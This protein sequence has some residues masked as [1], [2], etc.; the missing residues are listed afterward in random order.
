MSGTFSVLVGFQPNWS[1]PPSSAGATITSPGRKESADTHSQDSRP[2]S[3]SPRRSTICSAS[4]SPNGI[5]SS[6]S[7]TSPTGVVF[8]S[9]SHCRIAPSGTSTHSSVRRGRESSEA[10]AVFAGRRHPVSSWRPS[11]HATVIGAIERS[12]PCRYGSSGGSVVGTGEVRTQASSCAGSSRGSS[13]DGAVR[14]GGKFTWRKARGETSKGPFSS[15]N[16]WRKAAVSTLAF[17]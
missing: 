1:S 15:V 12:I 13:G 3:P 5:S 16:A 17:P 9:S 14:L 6:K 8:P 11:R 10:L 4:S 7:S 2:S